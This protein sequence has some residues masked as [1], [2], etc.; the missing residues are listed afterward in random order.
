M[1]P[2]QIANLIDAHSPALLLYARQFG[3]GA[4]DI[5]QEALLRLLRQR[6]WPTEVLPWLFRTVRNA[7][8]DAA[9]T[10]RR[11]DK[12]EL[13][14][15]RSARWF[16]E[17]EVEGLDADLAARAL[18]ELPLEMREAIVS[19]IWGGLTFEQIAAV[20]GTSASTAC[21]HYQV[22]IAL[23]R[24]KLGASCPNQPI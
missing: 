6:T 1:S 23:L 13:A 10:A 20:A 19:R 22:G 4:E 14:V 12:R 8:L 2:K 24:E 21:R 7:A 9:K 18:A 17:P 3:A 16:V 11:R 5:V 15:A